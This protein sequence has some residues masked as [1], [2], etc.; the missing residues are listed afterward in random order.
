MAICSDR[1]SIIKADR[2]FLTIVHQRESLRARID[3]LYLSLDSHGLLNQ[4][5]GGLA[6]D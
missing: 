5:G 2:D 6:L 4:T 1:C 3:S